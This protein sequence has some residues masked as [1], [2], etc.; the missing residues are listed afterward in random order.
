MFNKREIRKKDYEILNLKRRV[1]ELEELICPFNQHQFVEID[2][3]IE[4]DF[5]CGK[6][7]SHCKRTLQCRKCRRI[8]RDDNKVAGFKYKTVDEK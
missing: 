3:T 1:Y 4:P 7:D 6:I 8:V 2:Y 5:D